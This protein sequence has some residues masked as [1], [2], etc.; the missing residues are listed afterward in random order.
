M[1]SH[2]RALFLGSL[3]VIA[4]LTKTDPGSAHE[5]SR[6]GTVESLVDRGTF[7][8][9]GS[10]FIGTVDKI[11]R[12]GHYYSHQPPLLPVLEAPVYWAINLPGIRFN[13]RGRFVMTYLFI[14]LTNGL[15]LALTV[16]VTARIL[17]WAGVAPPGRD[18]LAALLIFGT[19]L[20]P[21]GISSNNHSVSALLVAV[22]SHLLLK[23]DS[24]IS[25]AGAAAVGLVLGL[26]V[27]IEILPLVSFLPLTIV[28]LAARR[29]LGVREWFA[30]AAGLAVPL[31][32]HA[33][34]N[35]RITGDVIPAG[36]HHELFAYPGSVFDTTTLTGTI[37][38]DSIGGA[39]HY[40][41]T[42]LFAGKGF[43][44]FAPLLLAGLIAGLSS[45][46]WWARARGVQLVLLGSIALSLAVAI[47]TTNNYGGEAVGFRHAAYLSPA[48]IVLLLPWLVES[49]EG[50]PGRRTVVTAIAVVSVALMLVFA[51]RQPWSVLMLTK[52]PIGTWGEYV[53]IIAK[54]VRGDLFNP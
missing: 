15:A 4:L 20:L 44:T 7:E 31:I 1:S 53:P 51:V 37:K 50:K 30:F 3:L 13:N 33:I 32:A 19:W 35:V 23:F 22:L 27:A 11:Y 5:Y 2:R 36:F 10:S 52:A 39:F 45:W 47:L 14:L 40:A 49:G 48:F 21:Y 54:V 26:L 12:D 29:L 8:L 16:V 9:D 34:L 41:W 43:F 24:T 46:Q 38:Y 42:S 28:Y 18:L 6:F 17:E 25:A